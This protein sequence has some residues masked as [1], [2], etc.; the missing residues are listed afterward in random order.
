VCFNFAGVCADAYVAAGFEGVCDGKE[1]FAVDVVSVSGWAVQVAFY[2]VHLVYEYSPTSAPPL[3]RL[4][5]GHVCT[6]STGVLG[7]LTK[8][9][10]PGCFKTQFILV[11]TPTTCIK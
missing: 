3:F 4:R 1:C 6:L 5:L 9:V 8:V 7:Q 2:V 11:V 10:C